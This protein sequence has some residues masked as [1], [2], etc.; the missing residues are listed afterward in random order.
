MKEIPLFPRKQGVF[1]LFFDA[2]D[3]LQ[4]KAVLLLAVRIFRV[5]D[6]AEEHFEGRTHNPP[7]PYSFR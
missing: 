3:L 6:L 5:V 4:L 1:S 7:S 2:L